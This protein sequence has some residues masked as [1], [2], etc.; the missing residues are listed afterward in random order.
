LQF[1]TATGGA[2][3]ANTN[4]YAQRR[5]CGKRHRHFCIKMS[6]GTPFDDWEDGEDRGGDFPTFDDITMDDGE[7]F[8]RKD[9]AQYPGGPQT[10]F[11]SDSDIQGYNDDT[12]AEFLGD[13]MASHS[14]KLDYK[15]LNAYTIPYDNLELETIMFDL[16]IPILKKKMN[17][18]EMRQAIRAH[19]ADGT[20][21]DKRPVVGKFSTVEEEEHKKDAELPFHARKLSELDT[22]VPIPVRS[23]EERSSG[24]AGAMVAA[25]TREDLRAKARADLRAKLN[26]L[27]EQ[28]RR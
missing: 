18:Q 11:K 22:R 8:Y 13:A 15:K 28:R 27:K 10:E 19:A 26:A 21:I 23:F 9:F 4:V 20:I 1:G 3:F 25:K 17:M 14:Y 24:F 6:S 16:K 7:A 2:A 5:N 12:D